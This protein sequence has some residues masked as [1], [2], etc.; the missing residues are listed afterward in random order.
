M[1]I[2]SPSLVELHAFLAVADT[3]SFR[4]AAERMFVT[5]AAVSRAVMRLEEQLGVDVFARSGTGVRLTPAGDELRRL[6]AQPV[7]ALEQAATRL[8]RSPDRLRLRL[9]VVTS[10][11]NLWLMPRLEDFRARHPEI[12][13]EFRPYQREDDFLREDVDLWIA[14]KRQARQGWPR[15]V[16]AEY[17]VGRE[18]VAVGAPRLAHLRA[19]RELLAQPL[20]YHSSYPE[21]WALWARALG[22]ELPPDWRGTGFDLVVNLIEAARGGMGVAV[23]QKCMVEA[24]LAAGRLVMPVPGAASTGRGYY[25]CRRRAM[26]AHPAAERFAQ[27]LLA[28][29]AASEP[30]SRAARPAT[31]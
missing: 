27:W 29:A 3:G 19:A 4:K 31:G 1:P 14:L 28:Q 2:R 15:Q 6:V 30:A 10:L 13:L 25:L 17:L 5:Q 7:A 11:G 24:D 12:E 20:L 18:I 23:V 26:G 22:A 16:A 8:Q 21:N 9:S